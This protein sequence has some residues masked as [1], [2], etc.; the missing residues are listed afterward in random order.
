M[1]SERNL[2][3]K[4]KK[5]LTRSPVVLLTGAR[6]PGKTT[7]VKELESDYTYVTFDNLS[8]LSSAQTDPHGFINELKKPVI[9]DEA[10]R[11][12][13]LFYAIK[14]SVDEQRKPGTFLLTG[15]TSPLFIQRIGDAL[16]GRVEI[17]KLQPFSQGELIGRA[18]HFIDKIRSEKFPSF[19]I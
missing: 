3:K 4:L 15:S 7:L 1:K 10:Q 2:T 13:E 5:A 8:A 9:I 17:L 6:Q 18:E 12:P 19:S 16:V 14:K 11:V